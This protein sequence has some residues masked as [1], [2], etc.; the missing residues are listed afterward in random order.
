MQWRV[1]SVAFLGNSLHYIDP[2]GI[3][4]AGKGVESAA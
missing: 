4:V 1:Y 2:E 3:Y